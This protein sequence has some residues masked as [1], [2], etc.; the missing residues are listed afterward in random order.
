[1]DHI[2]LSAGR[3]VLV[4]STMAAIPNYVMQRRVQP[5]HLCEKLDKVNR[6]FLWGTTS[7]KRKM[8]LVGWNKIIKTK[9]NGGL[10]IQE[11]RA[12]NIAL[13]A[14]LNRRMNQEK[15]ALWSKIILRKYCSSDRKRSRDP[16]KLPASPNWTTIKLG[17]QT[18][19]KGIC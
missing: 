5:V 11:V 3:S 19:V 8:H 18:F 12:K 2:A 14:K 10:G 6:D 1:M 4:K 16:D 17:F 15:D 7:E 9:E 13:L